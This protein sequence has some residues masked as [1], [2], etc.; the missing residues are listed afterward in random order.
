MDQIN[1]THDL[2]WKWIWLTHIYDELRSMNRWYFDT[3]CFNDMTSHQEWLDNFDSL[4]NTKINLDKNKILL[5]DL[6]GI[7]I[8]RR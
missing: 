1:E 3:S 5:Y 4:R 2:R 8:K 6:C 7:L